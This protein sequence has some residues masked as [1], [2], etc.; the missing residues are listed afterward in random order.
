MV[1]ILD[2]TPWR[3][4]TFVP[5]AYDGLSRSFGNLGSSVLVQ[6]VATHLESDL[7]TR[8]V[9]FLA[10]S[11]SLLSSAPAVADDAERRA[12][13]VLSSD[14]VVVGRVVEVHESPGA[15]CGV[16]ATEQEV[17]YEVIETLG[18]RSPGTKARIR[19][20][21]LLVAGSSLVDHAE[22]RLNPVLFT[23]GAR[24][25]V[26]V[27]GDGDENHTAWPVDAPPRV[28]APT[29]A[30][31]V[32]LTLERPWLQGF[33]HPEAAGRV[34]LVILRNRFFARPPTLVMH[35]QPVLFLTAEEI[36]ARRI[37]A[38]I[39][40]TALDVR[41]EAAS[42]R[43]AYDV[44]GVVGDVELACREGAW[45]VVRSSGAER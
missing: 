23:E 45:T 27:G 2:L 35:G 40:V 44:E 33:L 20:G 30:R 25:V 10:I 4:T 3:L 43:I 41:D 37:E 29:L 32:S 24:F 18:G 28:G 21:H 22:A 17:T 31:V 5:E 12:K 36:R 14:W 39:E 9:P 8:F 13:A 38:F 16:I 34:P 15:W 19:V 42:I 11:I 1:K 7:M 26:C 6:A